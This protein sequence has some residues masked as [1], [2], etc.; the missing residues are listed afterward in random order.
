ME[1][2]GQHGIYIYQEVM[3][4]SKGNMVSTLNQSSRLNPMWEVNICAI[5]F[6]CYFFGDHA[7]PFHRHANRQITT[8]AKEA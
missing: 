7:Q 3:W 8:C 5:T 1:I 2:K 6:K 4:R